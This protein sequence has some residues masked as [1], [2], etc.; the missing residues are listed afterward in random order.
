MPIASDK[1]VQLAK[2][3]PD[4]NGLVFIM[5]NNVYYRRGPGLESKEIQ[6]THDGEPGVKYNGVTDWVY[7]GNNLS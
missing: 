3:V 5:D 4:S 2:W 7:E 1:H 6:L